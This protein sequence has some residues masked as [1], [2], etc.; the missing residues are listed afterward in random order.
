MVHMTGVKTR[1]SNPK[2]WQPGGRWRCGPP[3]PTWY[4]RGDRGMPARRPL[5]VLAAVAVV[6]LVLAG[7]DEALLESEVQA[8]TPSQLVH[9][10]TVRP[11]PSQPE[12]VQLLL[13]PG[14][15]PVPP[16]LSSTRVGGLA[17][18]IQQAIDEAGAGGATLSVAALDRKTGEL[19]SN[20][21]PQ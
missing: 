3:T 2:L 21:N 13:G 16:A 5:T 6:T 7:C 14:A 17:T 11:V 19:V 1:R 15:M 18:R 10:A 20:G 12:T 8:K 4:V 9:S